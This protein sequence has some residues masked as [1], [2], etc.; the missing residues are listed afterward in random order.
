MKYKE[1]PESHFIP[2]DDE[3]RELM[4]TEARW[5][6]EFTP[7]TDEQRTFFKAAA[8]NTTRRLRKK[9]RISVYLFD[10]DIADIKRQSHITGIP[11][12]TLIASIVHQHKHTELSRR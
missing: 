11:Y 4:E 9:T 2:L 12:Q 7:V 10:E 3:E 5:D 6:I 1:L 8:E